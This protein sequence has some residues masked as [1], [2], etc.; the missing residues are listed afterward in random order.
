LA[1]TSTGQVLAWG[2]NTDGELG[3]GVISG[4]GT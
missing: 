4:P 2:Y 1:L 3:A